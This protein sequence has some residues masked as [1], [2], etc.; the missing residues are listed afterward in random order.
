MKRYWWQFN[1]SLQKKRMGVVASP[2]GHQDTRR[3][4][5]QSS[6]PFLLVDNGTSLQV[7]PRAHYA[8]GV[9][10]RQHRGSIEQT[11]TNKG[12]QN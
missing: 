7:T 1:K 12:P 4:C 5:P 6:L 9:V 10:K 2:L 3:G 8:T 11:T